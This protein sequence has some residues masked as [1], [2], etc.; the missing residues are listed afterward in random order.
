MV[1]KNKVIFISL[2]P[3]KAHGYV[4]STKMLDRAIGVNNII[5]IVNWVKIWD[6]KSRDMRKTKIIIIIKE[7]QGR[8]SIKLITKR[9]KEEKI[10]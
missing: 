2:Y 10:E 4:G 5:I 8:S 9:F 1:R 3:A 7:H 6:R